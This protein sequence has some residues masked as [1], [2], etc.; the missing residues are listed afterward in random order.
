[1]NRLM[2]RLAIGLLL[3]PVLLA[4]SNGHAVAHE[5][6]QDNGVSVVL[7]VEPNDSPVAAKPTK[8]TFE[9]SNITGGFALKDYVAT[10]KLIVNNQT[11]RRYAIEPTPGAPSVGNATVTFPASAVYEV[12][13]TGVPSAAGVPKFIIKYPLRVTGPTAA[14]QRAS[15]SLQAILISVASLGL[16]ALIATSNIRAGQKYRPKKT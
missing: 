1:M 3:F 10:V 15:A 14:S 4:W 7:H 13:L 2:W 5:L 12:V 6:A 11:V 16:L 8:L 9:L